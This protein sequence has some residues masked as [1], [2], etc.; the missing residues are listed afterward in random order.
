MQSIPSHPV[1]LRSILILFIHLRLG[2]PSGLFSSG[3]LP[4]INENLGVCFCDFYAQKVLIV[5]LFT[6]LLMLFSIADLMETIS[7]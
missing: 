2:L 4:K 3:F 6:L 5:L 1:S 7:A